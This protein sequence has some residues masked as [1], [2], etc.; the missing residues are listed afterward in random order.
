[1]ERDKVIE[2]IRKLLALSKSSNE[3]EAASALAKAQELLDRE[4][5]SLHEVGESSVSGIEPFLVDSKARFLYWEQLLFKRLAEVCDCFPYSESR[6]G[7]I[8]LWVVGHKQDTEVFAYFLD[9]LRKTI[10]M[11]SNRALAKEK[12]VAGVWDRKRAFKFRNSFGVGAMTRVCERVDQIRQT[13]LSQ[14]IACK[15]LIVSRNQDVA[16]WVS[17]NL[18]LKRLSKK[19]ELSNR[20]FDIGYMAG[21]SISLHKGVADSVHKKISIHA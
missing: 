3:H 11:L 1:M 5:L 8:S 13:R 19:T 20:G 2:K 4:N 10:F 17:S 16:E 6:R 15:A 14:S 18:N 21:N 9:F 12:R 7:K